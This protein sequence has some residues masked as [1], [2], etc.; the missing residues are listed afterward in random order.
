MIYP[1]E[2]AS[3][4]RCGPGSR[5]PTL[6]G[7]TRDETRHEF[8][9]HMIRMR[10][11]SL[12]D[13]KLDDTF[14]EIVLVNSHDGTSAYQVMGGLFRLACLNGM[15]VSESQCQTIKVPHKLSLKPLTSCASPMPRATFPPRSSPRSFWKFAVAPTGATISGEFLTARRRPLLAEV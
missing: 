11:Q 1:P 12:R 8:T 6:S 10:H 7:R 9:K 2:A 14:P 3:D 5:I 13:L 15:V 4:G